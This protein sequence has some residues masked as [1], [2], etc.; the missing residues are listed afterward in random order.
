M[1]WLFEEDLGRKAF[2]ASATAYVETASRIASILGGLL[3][4]HLGDR[5]GP[6]RI[7]ASSY[8]GS[9][10]ITW[11]AQELTSPWC[12]WTVL[13]LKSSH[14]CLISLHVAPQLALFRRSAPASCRALAF[15][16]LCCTANGVAA[17]LEERYGRMRQQELSPVMR[18]DALLGLTGLLVLPF[19]KQPLHED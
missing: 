14:G 9:A 18:C 2:D 11:M 17:C 6:R 7:V 1:K 16:L 13:A 5:Y 12:F 19:L 15:S 4:G 3:G 8:L 10:A